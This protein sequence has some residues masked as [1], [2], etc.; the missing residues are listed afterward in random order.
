MSL[1][2]LT[3]K[4]EAKKPMDLAIPMGQRDYS[5]EDAKMV[6]RCEELYA[7]IKNVLVEQAQNWHEKHANKT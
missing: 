5:K 7:R 2:K 4:K 3:L 6:Q 1:F